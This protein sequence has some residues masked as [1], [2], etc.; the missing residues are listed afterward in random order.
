MPVKK[1]EKEVEDQKRINKKFGRII[2]DKGYVLILSKHH[3]YKNGIGYVREHRLVMEKHIRRYLK[4]YEVVHHINHNRQ[5]NRIE[6]LMIMSS[7]G[8]SHLH[9]NDEEMR[10]LQSERMKKVRS[11]KFW[12]TKKRV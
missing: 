5:D 8:H 10:R 1:T 3:P 12:S 6:N 2:N 9:W 7:S 11:E 4:P